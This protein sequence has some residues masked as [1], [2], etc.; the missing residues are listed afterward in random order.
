[1]F[2]DILETCFNSDFS[3]SPIDFLSFPCEIVNNQIQ[4]I[5]EESSSIKTNQGNASNKIKKFRWTQEEDDRLKKIVDKKGAKNWE[6]IAKY[7][8][9]RNAKQCRERWII[10]FDDKYNHNNWTKEEDDF[11][12]SYQKQY[13]NKFSKIAKLMDSRSSIQVKNRWKYLKKHKLNITKESTEQEEDYED[14]FNVW[15]DENTDIFF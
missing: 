13:G 4:D 14:I 3:L 15:N 5:K 2:D 12:I 9:G 7:I 1:M 8:P 11:L 6:R 10:H